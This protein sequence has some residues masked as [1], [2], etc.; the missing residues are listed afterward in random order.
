[1]TILRQEKEEAKQGDLSGDDDF[2]INDGDLKI[3]ALMSID[4][5]PNAFIND[6]T[7]A[8]LGEHER[9]EGAQNVE[10]CGVCNYPKCVFGSG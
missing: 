3:P 10:G 7:N 4:C 8:A 2:E 9:K 5:T 6:S 1:M